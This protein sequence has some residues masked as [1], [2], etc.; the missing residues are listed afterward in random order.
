M[1]SKTINLAHRCAV[2]FGA[3]VLAFA[4]GAAVARETACPQHYAAGQ[5]PR[6]TN[7]KLLSRTAE[8]CFTAF[9]V[10]HS[11]LYRTPLW[12]AEHLTRESLGRAKQ[13]VR[14]NAFHEESGLAASDRSELRDFARS[15]LD[16]GH[17]APSADMPTASTQYES[18]SL[19][20]MIP[21]DPDNNRNLWEG[22]ESAVRTL[23]KQRGELYVI[24][25]PLFLAKQLSMLNGR[26][27][28][29][30]Q[31]FKVVY[32]PQRGAAAYLVDN[33][34]G[35]DYRVVPVARIEQMAGISLLPGVAAEVKATAMQLPTPTPHGNRSVGGGSH[36]GIPTA[37]EASKVAMKALRTIIR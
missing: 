2:W 26:V 1:H 37:H 33:A 14:E 23:A 35:M 34:A 17:L 21:Q 15:G 10:V 19:A 9:G 29:P 25:G 13:Q 24:S 20:N 32:D 12:S 16:R 5:A 27:Y 11:G 28:V 3:V 6:I 18:F 30:T 4:A 22:I 31:I 36:H 8:L 7:P